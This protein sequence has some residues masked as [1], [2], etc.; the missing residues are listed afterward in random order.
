MDTNMI[1]DK[2]QTKAEKTVKSTSHDDDAC[3]RTEQSYLRVSLNFSEHAFHA[4]Y[5]QRRIVLMIFSYAAAHSRTKDKGP[6]T[7]TIEHHPY[8]LRQRLSPRWVLLSLFPSPTKNRATRIRTNYQRTKPTQTPPLQLTTLT[9]SPKPCFR[10][11]FIRLISK[12]TYI[13]MNS[14]GCY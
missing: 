7:I 5:P 9:C 11:C 6:V 14:L 3:S 4:R 1:L 12:I 2:R 13:S 8:F 10:I